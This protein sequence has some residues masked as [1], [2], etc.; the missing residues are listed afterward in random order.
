M[1]YLLIFAA[2][3]TAAGALAWWAVRKIDQGADGWR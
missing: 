3:V 2:V 1:W